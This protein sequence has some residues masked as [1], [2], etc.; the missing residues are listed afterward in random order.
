MGSPAKFASMLIEGFEMLP[1]LYLKMVKRIYDDL[2]RDRRAQTGQE[3]EGWFYCVVGLDCFWLSI[4]T[5]IRLCGH[6][7]ML[8]SW[9]PSSQDINDVLIEPSVEPVQEIVITL[10][11][12]VLES[13]EEDGRA[14]AVLEKR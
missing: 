10:R 6:L 14:K 13:A 5:T 12:N 8:V 11:F 3:Q 4:G 9:P 1:M 2:L 7:F